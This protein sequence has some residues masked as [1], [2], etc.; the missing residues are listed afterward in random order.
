MSEQKFPRRLSVCEKCYYIFDDELHPCSL[1][2]K[3]LCTLCFVFHNHN[4]LSATI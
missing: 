2:L 4:N 3:K 1:C